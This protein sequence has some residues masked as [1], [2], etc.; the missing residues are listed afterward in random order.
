MILDGVWHLPE[1]QLL[2]LL[3]RMHAELDLRRALSRLASPA[4]A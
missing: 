2:P 3:A 1:E 4:R